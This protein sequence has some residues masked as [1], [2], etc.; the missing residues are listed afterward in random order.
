MLWSLDVIQVAGRSY[1]VS[2]Q[3]GWVSIV[4]IILLSLNIQYCSCKGF[5]CF[6]YVPD[7]M[8]IFSASIA[9]SRLLLGN[10]DKL[11]MQMIK[12]GRPL[13]ALATMMYS[14]IYITE[15]CT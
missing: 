11:L 8:A 7:P 15:V 4:G 13:M 14:D 5:Y 3:D 9:C 2:A 10:H 12:H 6:H 1:C